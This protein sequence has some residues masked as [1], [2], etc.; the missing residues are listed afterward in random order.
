LIGDGDGGGGV[1]EG[2]VYRE[3]V[4]PIL[5]SSSN[6]YSDSDVTL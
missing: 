6:S 3:S 4:E 5:V 1:E 2:D